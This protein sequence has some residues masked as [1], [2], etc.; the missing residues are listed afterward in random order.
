MPVMG[1]IR[2]GQILLVIML[3]I[4]LTAWGQGGRGRGA[5]A[6]QGAAPAGAPA[7]ATGRAGGGGGASEFYNYDPT[8]GS[9]PAIPETSPTETHQKITL[10]GQALAYTARAGYMP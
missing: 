2:N 1:Y 10:N 9:G 4:S 5:P 3:G 7:V 6:Q 8:A